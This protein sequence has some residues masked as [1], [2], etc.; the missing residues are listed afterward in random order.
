M[1]Y[2]TLGR[3][4]VQIPVLGAGTYGEGFRPGGSFSQSVEALRRGFELGMTLV[5]TAESYGSGRAE[6]IV[7]EAVRGMRDN[8]FI[9]TKVS[10]QNLAYEDV[11]KSAEKSLRRLNTT[12]IDLYQI[13]WPNPR[14]P[15]KETMKAMEHLLD[16]GKIKYVGVSNFSVKETEEARAA[17]S[18]TDLVSNQVEYNLLNREVELDLLPYCQREKITLIAYSPLAQGEILRSRITRKLQEMGEKYGKTPLQVALNWLI[19]QPEVITIPKAS[20][21]EHV[22]ENAG[23]AGWRLTEEDIRKM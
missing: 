7:G 2:K 22:E 8:I 11:L 12:I 16:K 13:H 4:G 9:A 14:I 21:I 1:D 19:T 17:F 6:E 23:A 20:K 18:K 10:P 3:T 5:D 15:V